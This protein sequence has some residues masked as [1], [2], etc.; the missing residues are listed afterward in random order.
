MSPP[1]NCAWTPHQFEPLAPPD[2]IQQNEN[3]IEVRIYI[4]EEEAF[5]MVSN[6]IIVFFG[7]FIIQKYPAK[8]H[9]SRGAFPITDSSEA[10][11]YNSYRIPSHQLT[12]LKRARQNGLIFPQLSASID[13]III[14]I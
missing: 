7:V 6:R 10:S 14:T 3:N 1:L 5:E 2:T 4:V 13:L 12:K 9:S 8:T 11:L